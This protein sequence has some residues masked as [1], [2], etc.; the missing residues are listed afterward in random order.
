[1]HHENVRAALLRKELIDA[2]IQAQTV[3]SQ[4]R[5]IQ[6]Q[7]EYV[8]ALEGHVSGLEHNI[9]VLNQGFIDA[10]ARYRLNLASNSKSFRATAR[11]RRLFQ[12]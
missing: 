11:L 12:K 8:E 4:Q 7:Q 1:M 9:E 5:I 10:E 3:E 2:E 6:Q